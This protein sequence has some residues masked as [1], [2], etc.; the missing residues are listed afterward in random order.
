M[1]ATFSV[2]ILLV[3]GGFIAGIIYD[4]FSIIKF[5]AKGNL[6]AVIFKDIAVCLLSGFI[7]IH[8]IF[9]F[10]YGVFAF[11]EVLSFVVGISFEQIFVKNLIAS[12]IKLVYNKITLRKNKTNK[13]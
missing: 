12:P 2:M 1:S 7:F 3:F 4:V 10:N 13:S 5:I 9:A 6:I 8:C 11:F